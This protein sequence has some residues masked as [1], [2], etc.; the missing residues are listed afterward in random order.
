MIYYKPCKMQYK[1]VT[2]EIHNKKMQDYLQELWE[3]MNEEAIKKKKYVIEIK[4]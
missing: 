4:V 2:L 3:C 1:F